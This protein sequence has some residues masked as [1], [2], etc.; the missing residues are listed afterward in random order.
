MKNIFII[1]YKCIYIFSVSLLAFTKNSLKFLMCARSYTRLATYVI[2]LIGRITK[3][4]TCWF[5]KWKVLVAQSCPT[6]CD[7]M[8]YSPPGSSVHGILK[9]RTLKWVAIPFS[10]GSSQFRNWTQVFFFAGRFFTIWAVREAFIQSS[11]TFCTPGTVAITVSMENSPGQHTGV[12][13]HSLLQGIFSTSDWTWVSIMADS[14]Y[15]LNHQE[16]PCWLEDDL[17]VSNYWFGQ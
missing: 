4:L 5:E 14:L 3:C 12:G 2:I 10:R 7:P 17:K 6:L 13:I 8:H 11:L 16:S 9:E 1:T 15:H